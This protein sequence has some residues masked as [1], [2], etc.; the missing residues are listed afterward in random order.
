MTGVVLALAASVLWGLSDFIGGTVSR[1]FS[2]ASVLFGVQ[3]GGLIAAVLYLPVS[4]EQPA[5][6]GFILPAALAG[7]CGA[8]GLWLYYLALAKGRM[9]LVAPPAALAIVVPVAV[10]VMGGASFSRGAAI[11]LAAAA[12]GMLVTT[13]TKT[14]G[15]ADRK[16]LAL[17]VASAVVVGI[18]MVFIAKAADAAPVMTVIVMR[19][20]AL[21]VLA[22][23]MP[24]GA[25]TEPFPRAARRGVTPALLG[26]LGLAGVSDVAANFSFALA[27]THGTLAF[28]AILGSLHPIVV[29][30]FAAARHHERLSV[31]QLIGGA[32]TLVGVIVIAAAS[33]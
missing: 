25:K 17:A 32:L 19:V 4:H 1:R 2:A 24:W 16:P 31:T 30:L 7:G 22:G 20:V 5:S 14:L 28:A 33:A 29:T 9:G 21:V 13:R 12:V 18:G 8:I 11:G 15:A 3:A 6:A 27:T 23:L 26:I 10:S